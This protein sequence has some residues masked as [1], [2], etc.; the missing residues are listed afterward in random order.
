MACRIEVSFTPVEFRTLRDRDL[1]RTTCVVF[2]ILRATSS[3]VAALAAGARGV[4]PVGE[5]AEAVAWRQRQP[6]VLLAGE[7]EG[8]RITAEMSG[9]VEFDLGNSPREFTLEM[10]RDRDIV[11]TTTNGTRALQACAGAQEILLGSFLNLSATVQHL[12]SRTRENICLVAAGTGEAAAW[13]DTLA[14]GAMCDRLAS[15]ITAAHLEDSALIA[16][17][18]FLQVRPNLPN[19]LGQ[20]RNARRLLSLP[21]LHDDVAFCVQE[22]AFDFAAASDPDG[23]LRR[24]P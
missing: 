23:W 8:L 1:S 4:L 9:G 20:A 5:I 17:S 2:D 3:M 24:L 13:E 6:N 14:V 22:D 7:R 18:A 10:V 16:R 15:A 12:A 11:A 19:A 21:K